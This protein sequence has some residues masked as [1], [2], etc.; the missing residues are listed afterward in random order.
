VEDEAIVKTA[1][2]FIEIAIHLEFLI[3]P[4]CN[5]MIVKP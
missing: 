2:H 4:L 5:H 3:A 1:D